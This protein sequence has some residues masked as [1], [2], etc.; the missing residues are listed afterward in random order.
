MSL[1]PT[2]P[3]LTNFST[4][5]HL[6][7]MLQSFLINPTL[8]PIFS[9]LHTTP[10]NFTNRCPGQQLLRHILPPHKFRSSDC[11]NSSAGSHAAVMYQFSTPSPLNCCQT[12]STDVMSVHTRELLPAMLAGVKLPF[13]LEDCSMPAAQVRLHLLL[14]QASHPAEKAT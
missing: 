13:L 9:N 14:L 5:L 1:L 8:L 10:S 11:W 3:S 4:F 6:V 2:F 12:P 7:A